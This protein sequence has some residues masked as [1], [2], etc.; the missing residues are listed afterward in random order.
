MIKKHD[1]LNKLLNILEQIT[2]YV[3]KRKQKIK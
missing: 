1:I 3:E 2:I